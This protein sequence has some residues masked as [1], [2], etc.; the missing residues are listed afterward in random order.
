MANTKPANTGQSQPQQSIPVANTSGKSTNNLYREAMNS[1]NS[2][3]PANA[4]TSQSQPVITTPTTQIQSQPTNTLTP[5]QN[6]STISPNMFNN[7]NNNNLNKT[8]IANI[9]KLASLSNN[10]IAKMSQN[11]INSMLK[12]LNTEN[13]KLETAINSNVNKSKI[14]DTNKDSKLSKPENNKDTSKNTKT[15]QN[16]PNKI[17]NTLKNELEDNKNGKSGFSYLITIIIIIVVIIILVYIIKYFITKY[18]NSSY[19]ASYLLNNSKNAKHPLA[20]TQD[21]TSVNYIP[22]KR[23]E[24]KNGIQFSYGFWFLIDNF[25]YKKGEWKHMF[26][27]GNDSSYP[28]RAPGVWIHPNTNAIRVYMNTQDNILEYVDIDNIPMRKWVYMNIILSQQ[29][30]DNV[31][32]NFA[33]ANK[34]AMANVGAT[35]LDIYINGYLKIRKELKSIPKQNDDDLWINMYGGFEGYMSNI[36]YYSY[37]IDYN[38][39]NNMINDGPSKN[40]CIDTGEIPPYMDDNWWFNNSISK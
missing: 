12:K 7:N 35:N 27:K 26:H 34:F 19:N 23:S 13:K 22:I 29:T 37:A 21:P 5:K 36:R 28:N 2:N 9:N 17:T 14:T 15:I 39:I 32:N 18:Q 16:I 11:Q 25:D 33:N 31:V 1:V 20:I 38:E 3:K 6:N 8:D 24:G 10:D 40:N 4:T 30:I